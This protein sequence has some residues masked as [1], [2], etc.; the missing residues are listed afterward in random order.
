[1]GA[2]NGITSPKLNAIIY[3]H[4]IL[5]YVYSKLDMGPQNKHSMTFLGIITW[6]T[7]FL[8]HQ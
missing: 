7:G 8:L 6:C 5:I 2:V 4:L 3:L 1:M